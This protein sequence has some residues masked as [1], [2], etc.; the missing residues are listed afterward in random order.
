MKF[1]STASFALILFGLALTS[2]TQIQLEV[3]V[4]NES[5]SQGE[6]WVGVFP[7]G[8]TTTLDL[9]KWKH[10]VSRNFSIV[11]PTPNESS[12]LVFLQKDYE[13]IVVPLT[14]ERVKTGI[15]L[16]FSEGISIGGKVTSTDGQAIKAGTVS[17][18]NFHGF[19]FPLP[20]PNLL[21]WVVNENGTYEISGLPSGSYTLTATAANFMP[22]NAK[23]DLAANNQIYETNFRLT[24]ATFVEGRVF[25]RH[26]SSVQ[27]NIEIV[28]TSEEYQTNDISTDFDQ[29]NNFRIGPFVHGSGVELTV[30]DTFGRRSNPVVVEAPADN[31][32]LY[33]QNLVKV[34]ATVE[35]FDTGEPIENI[36]YKPHYGHLLPIRPLIHTFTPEGRLE[37]E[38]HELMPGLEIRTLGYAWWGIEFPDM[39][40]REYFDLGTIKLEP[41]RTVRGRVTCKHTGEPLKGAG[42][43]A[44]V[45]GSSIARN[46]AH[47]DVHS[48]TAANG[49]FQ[50]TG[51][52]AT[53][54]RTLNVGASGYQRQ[55]IRIN[56]TETYQEI[57]LELKPEEVTGSISG[58]VVSLEGVPLFDAFVGF[59]Y[60]GTR[61]DEDGNFYFDS[62]SG[63]VDT[64]IKAIAENRGRSKILEVTVEPGEHVRDF[65]L[66]ITEIGR[67][68][69]QVQGLIEGE[70]ARIVVHPDS[71]ETGFYDNAESNG[72]Y[73]VLGLSVGEHVISCTTSMRR[74]LTR[75]IEIDETTDT[76]LDFIFADAERPSA[77]VSSLSGRIVAAGHPI[78][79][80]Q[81][82]IVPYDDFLTEAR[83]LSKGDGTYNIK[84]LQAGPYHIKVDGMPQHVHVEGDTKLDFDLGPHEISGQ[85]KSTSSVLDVGIYLTGDNL[86]VWR[87]HDRVDAGGIYRFRGL[88]DGT[89][90]LRTENDRFEETIHQIK[91]DSSVQNFDIVLEPI[92]S[93]QMVENN[94]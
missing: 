54:A 15:D 6:V 94:K 28:V 21:S 18:N 64:K 40:G 36:V 52:P 65:S 8:I 76:R 55:S 34:I 92:D 1:I 49:E 79:Y 32:K 48:V 47:Y 78:P 9:D 51:F 81:V 12:S 53:S 72:P 70:S 88:T 3:R 41:A 80:I 83:A 16:E 30:V 56:D 89:Y 22:A 33:L 35:N 27:A 23:V 46:F 75:T 45:G 58:K 26:G 17:I 20:D 67:V 73:E 87:L 66:V 14:L 77:Q 29:E 61:T 24:K 31:V 19:N 84:G 7:H 11:V 2:C 69:G 37:I 59:S 25:D 44:W 90:E 63:K 43:H 38:L 85:I 86:R 5:F 60:R 93:E 62:V 71:F 42:L 74:R 10:E 57:E 50:I 13:P 39:T 91:I 68:H 82:E 4:K